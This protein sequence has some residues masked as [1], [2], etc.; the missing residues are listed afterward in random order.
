VSWN[1]DTQTL[2]CD[3]RTPTPSGGP[4]IAGIAMVRCPEVAMGSRAAVARSK[5]RA[6]GWSLNTPI[7]DRCRQHK[8][9]ATH[10][11]RLAKR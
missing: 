11:S 2:Q 1:A 10:P 8:A 9:R 4:G 7:G 3:H 6:N 5:A